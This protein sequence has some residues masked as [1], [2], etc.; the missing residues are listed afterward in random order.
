[1][2][3]HHW[4]VYIAGIKLYSGKMQAFATV[5]EQLLGLGDAMST[6]SKHVVLTGTKAEFR[7]P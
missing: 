5:F 2:S 4:Q 1:M 3:L 7:E 6:A